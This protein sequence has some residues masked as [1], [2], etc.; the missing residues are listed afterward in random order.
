MYTQLLTGGNSSNPGTPT[1]DLGF[2]QVIITSDHTGIAYNNDDGTVSDTKHTPANDDKS[3]A[4]D[5]V[6]INKATRT[7][8]ITRLGV[9]SDRSYTY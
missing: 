5:F 9:G 8:T 1:T 7:V 6:T 4:I 3:H 2:T